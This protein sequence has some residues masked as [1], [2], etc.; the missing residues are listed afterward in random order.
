MDFGNKVGD[1]LGLPHSMVPQLREVPGV[2]EYKM[3]AVLGKIQLVGYADHY[4][5]EKKILNENKTSQ[6]KKRWNKK[7]V[8]EHTQLDMYALLLFLSEKTKPEDITMHLNYIP[9]IENQD[10]SLS[11]TDPVECY[12]FTTVRTSLDIVKYANYIQNTHK[13][14]LE[15]AKI[16]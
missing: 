4:C 3:E 7:T 5:P 10:F 1:T 16:H 9:V 8:D 11:L 13:E 2:K 14:M 12:T 6:N 15:Y